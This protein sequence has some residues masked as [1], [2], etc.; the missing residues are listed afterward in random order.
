MVWDF[1]NLFGDA[2][3]CPAPSFTLEE[4]RKAVVEPPAVRANAGPK[5]ESAALL[6]ALGLSLMKALCGR[7]SDGGP[8]AG[9]G[10]KG[11]WASTAATAAAVAAASGLGPAGSSSLLTLD[12]TLPS[13][14]FFWGHFLNVLTWPEVLRRYVHASDASATLAFA[15]ASG[16]TSVSTSLVSFGSGGFDGVSTTAAAAAVPATERELQLRRNEHLQQQEQQ[17]HKVLVLA[18]PVWRGT[19]SFNARGLLEGDPVLKDAV[20]A[21]AS[22]PSVMHLEAKHLLC[23]LR[24]LVNDAIT[25]PAVEEKVSDLIYSAEGR[26]EEGRDRVD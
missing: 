20:S 9:N 10:S 2:L 17:Q 3:P 21:L 22:K 19:P 8:A 7:L 16:A 13:S 18:P 23:L 12:S 6:G 15:A 1:F 24:F 4:L 5:G 25:L 11:G 14:R 26:G